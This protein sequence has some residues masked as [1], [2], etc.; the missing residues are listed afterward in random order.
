MLTLSD[1]KQV[2]NFS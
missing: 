2:A 1:V